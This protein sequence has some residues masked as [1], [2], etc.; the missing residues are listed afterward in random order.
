VDI[1]AA[2][3]D[4]L[5]RVHDQR[6]VA[7]RCDVSDSA[8]VR[9]AVQQAA[10]HFKRID[11]VF[12]NAGYGH[13][14]AAEELSDAE[15]RRQLDVN[16][17]GNIN[18]VRA[19]LPYLRKQRSGHLLQMSSLNG[20]EG[21]AGGSYYAASKFAIEGFSESLANEIAPF[22]IKVTII[23]PGPFRTRF[24]GDESARW[25]TPMPEYAVTVGKAREMLRALNGRQPGDPT[26]AARAILRVV[27]AREPPRRLVLG[28][29]A[30]EHVRATLENRLD[31]LDRW[32]QPGADFP[33]AAQGDEEHGRPTSAQTHEDLVRRAYAA[34]NGRAIDA[35]LELLSPDV[36]WPNAAD[37]GFVHGRDNVAR[38]WREQFA[39]ADPRVEVDD[40]AE[41]SRD[42]V[43]ANV[44]QIVR[45]LGGR[46]LSDDRLL[47]VFTIAN[48]RIKRL[49]VRARP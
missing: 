16:L 18:V 4:E 2:P 9:H 21:L 15:L 36:D 39:K 10:E 27:D 7:L 32:A 28:A 14:G 8:A 5:A 37:G 44:H 45:D 43:E 31:E 6:V 25:A 11:I 20:V 48:N 17:L 47:H 29:M 41:T 34:F 1:D 30:V 49:D 40:V 19:V 33:S 22:G 46:A 24:L 38:H 13:V 12:N 35:A 3:I 42:R 23:E 26:R